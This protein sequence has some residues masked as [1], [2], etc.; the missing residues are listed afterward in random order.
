MRVPAATLRRSNSE[1]LVE[2]AC[3][4]PPCGVTLRRTRGFRVIANAARASSIPRSLRIRSFSSMLRLRLSSRER[5]PADAPTGGSGAGAAG[6]VAGCF[7]GLRPRPFGADEADA[8]GAAADGAAADGAAADGAAADREVPGAPAAAFA[9]VVGSFR[10]LR[11]GQCWSIW[12]SGAA[13]GGGGA[14]EAV[15]A[16]GRSGSVSDGAVDDAG[17]AAARSSNALTA[18]SRS[19]SVSSSAA[20][21]TPSSTAQM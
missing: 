18:R 9:G 14:A 6:A 4:A 3:R 12:R 1:A 13:G 10:G 11:R 19:K 21:A 20:S 2:A 17:G 15:E 7:R 8:D 5:A 16:A